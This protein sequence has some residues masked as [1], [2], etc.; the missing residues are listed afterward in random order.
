M[1]VP[2]A[3]VFGLVLPLLV[4]LGFLEFV[5]YLGI[6]CYF[7]MRRIFLPLDIYIFVLIQCD[8]FLF[9]YVSLDVLAS[10]VWATFAVLRDP[11]LRQLVSR[12]ESTVIASRATGTTNA[13]RRA[14]L[15]WRHFEENSAW[16]FLKNV[17]G[18]LCACQRL[19]NFWDGDVVISRLW[20]PYRKPSFQED[21]EER[22]Q[23][24]N[25]Q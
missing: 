20:I 6:Y 14:F 11:S 23:L 5:G 9:C 7:C 16:S 19:V 2:F 25:I 22:V 24:I 18:D 12:L 17:A 8:C 1:F 13:Y 4:E 21:P 3:S 10:G 15:R